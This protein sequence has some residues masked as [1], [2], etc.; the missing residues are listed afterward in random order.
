VFPDVVINCFVSQRANL[1]LYTYCT[2]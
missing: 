1:W 2:Q